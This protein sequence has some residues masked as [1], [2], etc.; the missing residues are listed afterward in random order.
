VERALP[1]P[2]PR[3]SQARRR[4]ARSLSGHAEQIQ[5]E[6]KDGKSA[7]LQEIARRRRVGGPDALLRW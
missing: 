4:A 1:F 5:P 3:G 2:N 7:R 6:I